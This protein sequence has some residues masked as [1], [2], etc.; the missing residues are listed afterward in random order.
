LE[1][2]LTALVGEIHDEGSEA[3]P[4]PRTEIPLLETDGSHAVS[5]VEE[6]LGVTL[7][8]GHATTVGGRLAEWLGRIPVTGERVVVGETEFDVLR[9][10]P[11]RVERLVVRR[12]PPI[13]AVIPGGEQ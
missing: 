2:L 10:S 13:A 7:L 12:S 6:R 8:S 4:E 5:D 3:P 9:A 11:A 1:D